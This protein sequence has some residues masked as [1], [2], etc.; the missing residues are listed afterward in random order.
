MKRPV[1][2]ACNQ[3]LCAINYIKED[4]VH[5]RSRCETCLRK[6]K[7]IK[8]RVPR[9]E[10]AGYKKKP[11]CDRCGFK[12]RHHSQ[13]LVFHVDG[14][15]DN[16]ELRNLKTVCLNCVADLR[17]YDSTWLPGDLEPDQ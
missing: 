5:Y 13:L 6:G 17:R 7:G 16:C 14:N 8:R 1:C 12:A 4:R 15:L 3:R 10:A 9:W 11:T 2:Q